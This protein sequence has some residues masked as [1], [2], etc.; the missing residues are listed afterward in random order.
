MI[1]PTISLAVVI[2]GPVASA[3]S[4]LNFSRARGIKAPKIVANIITI[5]SAILTARVNAK[6]SEKIR[7]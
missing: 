4:I 7:L 1:R 6:V 5:N 3:G 2:N